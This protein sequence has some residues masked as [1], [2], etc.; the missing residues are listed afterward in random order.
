MFIEIP[1]FKNYLLDTDKWLVFSL[2]SNKYLTFKHLDH[3]QFI[4]C[5]NGKR[6]PMELHR[7]IYT[8]FK[9]EIPEGYI[10][11]HIDGNP[12]NNNPDNLTIMER[13]AHV[14]HHCKGRKVTEEQK[15]KMSRTFFQKGHTPYMKGKHHTDE[16]KL[17]MSEHHWL[18]GKHLS[19][20]MKSNISKGLKESHKKYRKPVCALKDGIIVKEYPSIK[21]VSAD[22]FSRGNVIKCCQGTRKT[23]KGYQWRYKSEYDINIPCISN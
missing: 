10:V 16:T 4:L 22:G 14:I 5:E 12:L 20:N 6:V 18:K 1:G 19:D 11:H 2:Y 9:G 3:I 21:S 8:M 7:L 15:E 17:K 13:S 23:H